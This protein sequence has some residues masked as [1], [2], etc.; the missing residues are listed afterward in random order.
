MPYRC[1]LCNNRYCSKHRLPERHEC[2][3]IGVFQTPEYRQV[4]LAKNRESRAISAT[5]LLASTSS[6]GIST[7]YGN[8][9]FW[10]T[11]SKN[12]DALLAGAV[13]GVSTIIVSRTLEPENLI[14]MPIFGAILFLFLYLLRRYYASS[15]NIDTR[16]MIWPIGVAITLLTSLFGF[17]LVLFGFFRNTD[18]TDPATEAKIGVVTILSAVGISIAGRITAPFIPFGQDA[19][20]S[21]SFFLTWIAIFYIIPFRQLE[22]FKIYYWDRRVFWILVIVVILAIFVPI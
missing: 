4:K 22:G 1:S 2:I 16:F 21:V 14:L 15:K 7:R 3:N 12:Q 6:E 13:L 20:Y 9:D 8:I 5:Q 18:E 17:R 10:T 19:L 11:G